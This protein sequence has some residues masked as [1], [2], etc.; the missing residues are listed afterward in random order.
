MAHDIR[1]LIETSQENYDCIPRLVSPCGHWNAAVNRLYYAVFQLLFTDLVLS[2]KVDPNAPS[3]H[4]AIDSIA[5]E[6]YGRDI[7]NL[8]HNLKR[9]RVDV[10]YKGVRIGKE[11]FEEW[12]SQVDL[13]YKKLKERVKC[14]HSL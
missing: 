4:D 8:F 9:L 3:F 14:V 10:D 5:E 2:E 13:H 6:E 11:K 12:K 1:R 7:Y